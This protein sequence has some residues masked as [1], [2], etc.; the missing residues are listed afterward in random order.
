M[1]LNLL[2]VFYEVGNTLSLSQAANKLFI[3]QPAVSQNIKQLE[4]ELNLTL[5]I[6]KSRGVDL[7]E[8][9]KIVHEQLKLVFKEINTLEK[10]IADIKNMSDGILRIG[11][12]DTIC[13]HYLIDQLSKFEKIYP[14]LRYRV[15]NCTTSDSLKLLK[16]GLVDISF[17]HTPVDETGLHLIECLKLHDA[18]VCSSAFDTTNISS[19][20]DITK[21]RL[22]LLERDSKSRVYIDKVAESYGIEFKPKFE[23]ASLDVL[24]EFAKKNMGIIS[25][26]IE[27][28]KDDIK[29]G[30]LKEIKIK[31]DFKYR[32]ISLAISKTAYLSIVASKF[33]N[34]INEQKWE[35]KFL[36]FFINQFKFKVVLSSLSKR[37][38]T[39]ISS[40]FARYK[41]CSIILASV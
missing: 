1:E 14:N 32:S 38:K 6:R 26:P 31:E 21:Y 12:S 4:K 11:A 16:E 17:I 27:Y 41:Y 20:E 3:S 22:L 5:L 7:T 8:E 15:T 28:V 39:K 10:K 36:I 25:V 24:I 2:K 34:F 23:L 37:F 33:I 40:L 13:K 9:G 35:N 18:F 30:N 19:L 29:N